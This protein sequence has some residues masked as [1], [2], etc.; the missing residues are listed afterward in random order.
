MVGR[1]TKLSRRN[2]R[3]VYKMMTYTSPVFAHA[4]PKALD[5]L[6][7]IQN[8]FCASTRDAHWCVRN[9]IL[10]RDLELPTIAKFIKDASKR[11]FD[12]TGSHP[13]ALLRAAS[14]L[15]ATTSPPFHP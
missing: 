5:R 4:G 8:K 1:K 15:R 9:S 14:R 2:K 10:H 13:N 6:Q 3:I 11:F 7:L 12:I